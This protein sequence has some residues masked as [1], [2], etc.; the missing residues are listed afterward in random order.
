MPKNKIVRESKKKLL[1]LIDFICYNIVFKKSI[2]GR[3]E[4]NTFT[5]LC[6]KLNL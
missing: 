5:Y 3:I 1:Y 6:T 2:F 4:T